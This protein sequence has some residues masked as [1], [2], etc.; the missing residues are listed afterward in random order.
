MAR[1]VGPAGAGTAE[2][3]TGGI[4]G[5]LGSAARTGAGG[6]RGAHRRRGLSRSDDPDDAGSDNGRADLQ[7]AA[8][9]PGAPL[10]LLLDPFNRRRPGVAEP[11]APR[12]TVIEGDWG[13][14]AAREKVQRRLA[15][16]RWSSR[17]SGEG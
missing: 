16:S 8:E 3:A 6:S 9:D 1:P 15:S 10:D 4:A 12:F 2:E 7:D 17:S 11:D 13:I 5:V 14:S